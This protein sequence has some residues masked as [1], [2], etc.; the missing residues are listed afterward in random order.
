M[1]SKQETIDRLNKAIDAQKRTIEET[2]RA[3]RAMRTAE[4][5]AG[6]EEARRPSS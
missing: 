6:M 2:Q 1:A 5:D 3:A 4:G